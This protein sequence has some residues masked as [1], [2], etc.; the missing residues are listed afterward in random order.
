VHYYGHLLEG[1]RLKVIDENT[2]NKDI[3]LA[4]GML[5]TCGDAVVF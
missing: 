4:M 3:D 1:N 5:C 2:A